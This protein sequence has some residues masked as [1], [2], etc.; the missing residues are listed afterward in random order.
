MVLPDG[1]NQRWSLDFVSDSLVCGRRFRILCVVDDYT[2]ECLA[3]VADTSLSDARVAREL[4]GLL[5]MRGKPMHNG[6]VESFNGRLRD[7][8][9][10][11]TLFTSLA[12]ARFVLAAWRHDLNTVRP[13]SKLGGKTPAEIAG[14]RVWGASPQ[15]RWHPIKQSS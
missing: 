13:H 3:L 10:N 11:E 15:T 6:F 7:E 5:G 1:P 4:T 2:R 8:C 9:L 12:H 14:Q